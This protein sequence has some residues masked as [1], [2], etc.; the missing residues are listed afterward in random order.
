M[1]SLS[2]A[3]SAAKVVGQHTVRW[4]TWGAAAVL[5]DLPFGDVLSEVLVEMQDTFEA[6]GKD[7]ELAATALKRATA[8]IVTAQGLADTECAASPSFQIFADT[9][10]ELR[11]R[12]DKWKSKNWH[13]RLWSAKKYAELFE[14]LLNALDSAVQDLT[15][16][17]V[18]K[19]TAQTK[20]SVALLEEQR[21]N[22]QRAADSM[23]TAHA[24]EMVELKAINQKLELLIAN[25]DRGRGTSG[26]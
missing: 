12:A 8:I 13:K 15:L 21:G 17:L 11:A 22:C 1:A 7:D 14:K 23:A 5:K 19:A 9:L 25:S 18:S 26:G 20:R 6:C 2:A 16:A 24:D 3:G 10:M 4:L